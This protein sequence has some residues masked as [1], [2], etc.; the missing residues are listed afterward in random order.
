MA[1]IKKIR[2]KLLKENE[3][4][5]FDVMNSSEAF[6]FSSVNTSASETSVAVFVS[7]I[8]KVMN[9]KQGT[10]KK[11]MNIGNCKLAQRFR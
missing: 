8:S 6:H 1:V 9:A 3:S 5:L 11:N 2:R 10:N 7:Q 4:D